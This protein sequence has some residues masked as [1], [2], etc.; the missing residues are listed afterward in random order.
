ME[1]EQK[2]KREKKKKTRNRKRKR[3]RVG[4]EKRNT[5]RESERH[6]REFAEKMLIRKLTMH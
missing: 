4:A 2:R 6:S 1:K 5:G 3:G